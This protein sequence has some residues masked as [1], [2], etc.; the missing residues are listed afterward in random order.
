M[1]ARFGKQLLVLALFLT[2]MSGANLLAQTSD[3]QANAGG[4]NGGQKSDDQ[5]TDPLKRQVPEKKKKEQA[6]R[7]KT[8][9]SKSYKKWLDAIWSF[10]AKKKE[11]LMASATPPGTQIPALSSQISQRTFVA[12][13]EGKAHDQ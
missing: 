6:K 12:T 8:E 5:S 7:L 10:F 11:N 9:L 3:D 2:L 1:L 13:K 4:D